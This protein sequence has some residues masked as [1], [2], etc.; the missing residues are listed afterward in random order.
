[1]VSAQETNNAEPYSVIAQKI[2]QLEETAARRS[3]FYA[4]G[5]RVMSPG[6]GTSPTSND[7]RHP[8]AFR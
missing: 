4:D 6:F 1:M 7:V 3:S 8:V 5:A 2:L